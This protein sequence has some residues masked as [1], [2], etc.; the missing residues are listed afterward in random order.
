MNILERELADL[1]SQIK[2]TENK[3]D[4]PE[5][6]TLIETKRRL[7]DLLAVLG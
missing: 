5:R 2:Q 6:A 3:P 4:V 7:C 1:L